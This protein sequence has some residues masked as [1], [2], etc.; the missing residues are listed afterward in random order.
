MFWN[1]I[2]ALRSLTCFSVRLRNNWKFDHQG[3]EMRSAGVIYFICVVVARFV[4]LHADTCVT[5]YVKLAVDE[6]RGVSA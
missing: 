6:K 1:L 3:R 2:R 5:H 4:L